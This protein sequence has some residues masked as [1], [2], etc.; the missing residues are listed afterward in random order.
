[1]E[2]GQIPKQRYTILDKSAALFRASNIEIL[3]YPYQAAIESALVFVDE[4]V[5]VVDHNS[6]DRTWDAINETARWLAPAVT[7]TS[8]HFHFDRMWQ[9]KWWDKAA[10]CTDAEW[11]MWLD[12]DEIIDP[13]HYDEIRGAMAEP[14][15]HLLN[16]PFVHFYGTC[17]WTKSMAVTTGTR[18]GRR[19]EGYRMI[20]TCTDKTPGLATCRAAYGPQ[21]RESLLEQGPH[22]ARLK[23][24]IL[25]YGW[26]RNAKAFAISQA[27]HK[28]WYKDGDGLEDGRI[29]NVE[30]YDFKM[31]EGSIRKYTGRHPANMSSWL[32]AHQLPW[33]YL[34]AEI[35]E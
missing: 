30:P 6:Q 26:C 34:N 17:S 33:H 24:P 28:A 20:N 32:A 25:H 12:L 4:V 18:I 15:I 35:S 22:I 27:K 2:Y 31:K 29:P 10:S 5:V 8:M 11:L 7:V 9:E 1:L 19:S 3:D 14:N 21:M 16:F 13:I 23:T